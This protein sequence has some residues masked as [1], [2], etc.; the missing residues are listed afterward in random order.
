MP[1][2]P[3]PAATLTPGELVAQRTI[4][5]YTLTPAQLQKSEALHRTGLAFSLASTLFGLAVLVALIAVRFGPKVQRVVESISRRRFTQAAIF[6]PALLLTLRLLEFPLDVYGQHIWRAYG[7]SVQGWGSWLGD[8]AKAQLLAAVF[9]TLAVWALYAIIRRAP[10]RWWLYAWLA[11]LPV[12]AAMVFAAPVVIDPLFN[13]F[14]PLAGANPELT[15]QLRGLAQSAGLSVP[16]SR[17]FLMH[18]SDKVT[19]YNAYVT[20]FGATKRIV[21]WDT[22]ARDLTLPQTLFIFGHEMGHY[23]LHHIYL[24]MGFAA[25]LLLVGFC[26]TQRLAQAALARY[27]KRWHIRAIGDWSSLPLLLL[28]ASLVSFFGE[29][30]GNSFSRWQEHQ[31]DLY[32]LAITRPVTPDAGQVAAQAFQL[33]G[34]KSYSY[35]TPSP[36]LVFWS[37]SH[38]P[39]AERV[40]LALSIPRADGPLPQAEQK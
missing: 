20:G 16:E 8:W 11:A 1:A 12:M 18:A 32:G 13:R 29:P 22:T 25:V 4:T 9:A 37:Y 35:P 34:E 36:L 2:A 38:P 28:L 24:G 7:L 27:G 17:I 15:H 26:L 10:K 33:L 40:R 3:S 5:A 21:V 39:I 14:E 6:V 19:T 23:V 30:L 31:A